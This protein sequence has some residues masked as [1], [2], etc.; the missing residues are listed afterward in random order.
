[1]VSLTQNFRNFNAHAAAGGGGG[2][3]ASAGGGT[4][5]GARAG[6]RGSG[7]GSQSGGFQP[8]GLGGP[9]SERAGS[10]FNVHVYGSLIHQ[11]DLGNFLVRIPQGS[12]QRASAVITPMT[13]T[14]PRS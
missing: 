12:T 1:M 10:T 11:D 14:V 5:A 9:A 7:A 13:A 8:P 6:S 3:R 2:S 4:G